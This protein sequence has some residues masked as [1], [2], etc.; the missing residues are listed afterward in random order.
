MIKDTHLLV[1][2]RDVRIAR[3]FYSSSACVYSIDKQMSSRV[4]F[5]A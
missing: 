4:A 5:K 1:A 2:A 3:F